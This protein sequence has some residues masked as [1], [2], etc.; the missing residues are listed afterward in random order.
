MAQSHSEF[1]NGQVVIDIAWDDVTGKLNS[2]S[3][4]NPTP[5]RAYVEV[6]L[7]NGNQF[8][9]P[10]PANTTVTRDVPLQGAP[11]MNMT[12]SVRFGWPY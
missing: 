6:T 8:V 9:I 10:L 1:D 12:S 2:V 5:E 4:K 7:T 11:V 3:Y